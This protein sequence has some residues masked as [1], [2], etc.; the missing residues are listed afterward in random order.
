MTIPMKNLYKIS[1]LDFINNI[2]IA[3]D[4]D[5]VLEIDKYALIEEDISCIQYKL[6]NGYT[7]QRIK[8]LTR[9]SIEEY[10]HK[11]N[12]SESLHI[13]GE[14]ANDILT[15]DDISP[16]EIQRLKPVVSKKRQELLTVEV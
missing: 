5:V 2:K 13:L 14:V 16:E 1:P 11:I 12:Q 8:E 15:D 10:K 4:I 6:I 9:M 7:K 3:S